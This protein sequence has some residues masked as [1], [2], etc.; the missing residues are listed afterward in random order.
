MFLEVVISDASLFG[1][2][3]RWGRVVDRLSEGIME[4]LVVVL[5]NMILLVSFFQLSWRHKKMHGS[6]LPVPE[7]LPVSPVAFSYG[8]G[9]R[10]CKR[11]QSRLL[12]PLSHPSNKL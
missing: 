7:S 1:D 9:Y 5:V 10:E 6:R 4:G 2:R 12:D 8:L 3:D 11:H